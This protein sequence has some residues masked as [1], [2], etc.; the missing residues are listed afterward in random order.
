MK[1][2]TILFSLIFTLSLTANAQGWL[3]KLGDAAKNDA[4]NA[5]ENRVE[6]KADEETNKALDKIEKKT[7]KKK[8]INRI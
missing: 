5:V 2:L 8:S 6:K 7:S 3:N 1:K 4:K